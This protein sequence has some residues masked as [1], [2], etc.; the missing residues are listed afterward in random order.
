MA[1]PTRRLIQALHIA[2]ERI[3]TGAN[4]QWGHMGCCNCGH[5]AQALT[6]HDRGAIHAAALQRAGDWG[7]QAIEY[8]P[9]SGLPLD[10]IITTMLEAG[11]ELHDIDN[12]ERLRDPAVLDRLPQE[13]RWLRRNRREDALLYMRAWVALLEEQLAEHEAKR[14]ELPTRLTGDKVA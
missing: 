14:V 9:T 12:L 1:R 7:E 8:C 4:F 2:I 6:H 3:D 5:L 10:H 11:L 13:R